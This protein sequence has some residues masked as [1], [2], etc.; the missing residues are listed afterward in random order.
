MSFLDKIKFKNIFQYIIVAIIVIISNMLW[1]NFRMPPITGNSGFNIFPFREIQISL[2]PF[3]MYSWPVSYIPP[4]LGLPDNLIYA[5][6]YAV[7]GNSYSVATFFSNV[8][9]EIL[10]AF[11]VVYLSKTLLRSVGLDTRFAYVSVIFIIFNEE[12]VQ[13]SQFDLTVS[14]LAI[15]IGLFYIIIYKSRLYVLPLGIYSFFMLSSFPAGSL[16][17]SIELI[18]IFLCIGIMYFSNSERRRLKDI[19]QYIVSGILSFIVIVGSNA[20]MIYPFVSIKSLYFAALSASNPSYAFSFSF[21]KIEVIGNAIRL[22]NN[23]ADYSSFA[24]TWM[25]AYLSNPIIG[26]LLFIAPT[27]S[28]ASVIFKRKKPILLIFMFTIIL[29]F[30]S[31]ASN[32][33]MGSIFKWLIL[34]IDILRPFYNGASFSGFLIIAYSMLIG[35]SLSSIYIELSNRIA[36]SRKNFLKKTKK[37]IPVF[38]VLLVVG[39]MIASVYP[40]LSSQLEKGNPS[41]PLGSALP[42]YYFNASN[43]LVSQGNYP[44]IVFPE[45]NSFNSNQI[46]GTIWYNGVN[47]YP[48]IISSPSISGSYAL[49]YVGGKGSAYQVL[50]SIYSPQAYDSLLKLNRSMIFSSYYNFGDAI[51]KYGAY[52]S[53]SPFNDSVTY[54]PEN[55][56]YS[57]NKSAYHDGGQWLIGSLNR[58]VN[59]S[60]YNYLI[61]NYTS[62][63][64]TKSSLELG[65][66]DPNGAGNW[67]CFSSY[68]AVKEGN[69]SYLVVSIKNPTIDGGGSLSNVSDIVINFDPAKNSTGRGSF[70]LN[71][72]SILRSVKYAYRSVLEAMANDMNTLAIKYAYVDTSINSGNGTYYKDLFNSDSFLFPLIFHEGTIYIYRNNA[73]KGLFETKCNLRTYGNEADLLNG[74]Y[75]NASTSGI[76]V[77]SSNLLTHSGSYAKTNISWIASSSSVY[78]ITFSKI[79]HESLLLF[80]TDFNSAWNGYLQNGTKLQHFMAD[81]YAN[82]FVVPPNI[83]IIY[84]KYDGV[85]VYKVIELTMLSI[86]EVEFGLFVYV[87]KRRKI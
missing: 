8:I 69:L 58:T 60:F 5:L 82:G 31:K 22:I 65:L 3:N 57:V 72:Y 24:P 21:D 46:N 54:F 49:N 81:G 16:T 6:F 45:V 19:K 44:T 70:M 34:N 48:G 30:F 40:S 26:V 18:A 52:L 75:L 42:Q 38:I 43:F 78:T 74:L 63:N 33:P 73:Y 32:P 13:G 79:D 7:S 67:Y 41:T 85:T 77:N 61:L 1:Y 39:L 25:G 87:M 12:I 10:G 47:I 2:L 50:R 4:I 68:P 80:K 84:V 29:I 71:G 51:V 55:L 28:I 62:S 15:S 14:I 20:Y 66:F 83:T 11:S 86:P 56:T 35:V 23:W 36:N 17:Y 9:W 76:W 64:I 27:L 37:V 53:G 59:L